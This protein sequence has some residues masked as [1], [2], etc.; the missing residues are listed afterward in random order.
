MDEL[1]SAGK[2]AAMRRYE[3]NV[4]VLNVNVINFVEYF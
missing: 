1:T 3:E 2:C 4:T